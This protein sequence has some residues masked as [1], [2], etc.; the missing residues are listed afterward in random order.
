MA[1]HGYTGTWGTG[2]TF[3]AV[4]DA[5]KAARK[6]HCP[7]VSNLEIHY[8]PAWHVTVITVDSIEELMSQTDCVLLIDEIGIMMPSRFYGKLLAQTAMRWAQ[9][10]KYRVYEVFYTVQAMARVDAMVRELTWDVHEMRSFRLLGFFFALQY[11]GSAT[12]KLNEKI[13]VR[14]IWINKEV[15]GWYDTMAVIQNKNLFDEKK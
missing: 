3:T 2:K 11:Q 1:V 8:P 15:Y 7:V 10:R 5:G 13:G 14:F 12:S 6:Y 9:M 4:L